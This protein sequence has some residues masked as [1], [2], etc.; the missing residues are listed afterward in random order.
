MIWIFFN[1]KFFW[2][3]VFFSFWGTIT[4]FALNF[5]ICRQHQI[6]PEI[7]WDHFHH[8]QIQTVEAITKKPNKGLIILSC[9]FF[10]ILPSNYPP[11]LLHFENT[12]DDVNLWIAISFFRK[13]D[14]ISALFAVAAV[15]SS[16]KADE[17]KQWPAAAADCRKRLYGRLL[18]I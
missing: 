11:S 12:D 1:A 14:P 7:Y 3:Q 18:L 2:C 16:K 6:H 10:E 8:S 9:L 4:L 5:L 13:H 17:W 15:R